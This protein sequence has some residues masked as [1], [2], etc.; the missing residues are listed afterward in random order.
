ML[1]AIGRSPLWKMDSARSASF[2]WRRWGILSAAAVIAAGGMLTPPAA[3]AGGVRDQGRGSRLISTSDRIVIPDALKE[4]G[5]T[6]VAAA[7]RGAV[8]IKDGNVIGLVTDVPQDLQ[9]GGGVSAVAL[10]LGAGLAVKDGN[11]RAWRTQEPIDPCEGEMPTTLASGG[12]TSAVEVN[13]R[14]LDGVQFSF[15]IKNGK[16][17]QWGCTTRPGLL[18]AMPDDLTKGGV[19]AVKSM[20]PSALAIKDGSVHAWGALRWVPPELATGGGVT[21]IALAN[22][23]NTGL[24]VKDGAV[25]VWGQPISLPD[26]MKA[27][28]VISV[29]ANNAMDGPARQVVAVMDD[30][31]LVSNRPPDP[32]FQNHRITQVAVTSGAAYALQTIT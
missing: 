19:T 1:S 7:A 2:L 6:A 3:A 24:A 13:Q 31:S 28:H 4:G 22:D 14:G 20:G 29:S 17:Y 8:A 15:A 5:V 16:L 21:S 30:G 12:G 23:G 10:G 25:H 9:T 11:V 32:G 18:P 27:G 26:G